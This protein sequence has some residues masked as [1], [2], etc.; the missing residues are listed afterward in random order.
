MAGLTRR[1]FLALAALF[2][3]APPQAISLDEFVQLSQRL[4]GRPR[5]DREIGRIYLDALLAVPDNRSRL[6]R[7]AHGA[8]GEDLS[9]LERTIIEWWYTG[10]YTVAGEPRVATFNSA[11]MWMASGAPAPALCATAFGEWSKPPQGLV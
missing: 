4:V 7:L 3:A 1:A 10:V 5:L 8:T 6:D 11:L 2:A 9:G